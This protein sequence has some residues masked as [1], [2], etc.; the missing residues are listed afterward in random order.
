MSSRIEAVFCHWNAANQ[1][2]L[3]DPFEHCWRATVVP[4]AFWIDH[5]HWPSEANPQATN[6]AP[7][8][9]RSPTQ[10]KFAEPPFE[11]LPR[12][13]TS[14]AVAAFGLVRIGAQE[15]VMARG[16]AAQLVQ[17]S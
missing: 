11:K 15:D 5:R 17:R 2:F 4:D 7:Q 14:R 9:A 12:S 8:D 3:N 1:M 16:K 10:S 6:L 13:N